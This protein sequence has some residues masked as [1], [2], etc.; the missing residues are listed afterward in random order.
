MSTQE[1]AVVELHGTKTST[2]DGMRV[3]S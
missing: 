1:V 3:A 2:M